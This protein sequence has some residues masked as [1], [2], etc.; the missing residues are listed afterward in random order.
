MTIIET[1][2]LK[3]LDPQAYRADV[4]DRIQDHK[5]NRLDELLPW[6]WTPVTA[7]QAEAARSTAVLTGRLG[8][9]AAP[10]SRYSGRWGA[11]QSIASL[12]TDVRNVPLC[13]S[14]LEPTKILGYFRSIS[15]VAPGGVLT[16]PFCPPP[17]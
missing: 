12:L 15:E 17:R 4:L 14:S 13:A 3:G 9:A 10:M 1:A 7:A 2:K 8:F 5:I 16:A 11:R 6:N